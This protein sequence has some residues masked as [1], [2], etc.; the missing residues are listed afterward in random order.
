[1]VTIILME[2]PIFLISTGLVHRVL[3][4]SFPKKQTTHFPAEL[5]SQEEIQK[6]TLDDCVDDN[7]SRFSWYSANYHSVRHFGIRHFGIRH[8]GM[9]PKWNGS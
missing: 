8:S 6:S 9:F 2:S 1:M 5:R 7:L 3:S 4:A